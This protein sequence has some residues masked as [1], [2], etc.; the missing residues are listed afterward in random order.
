MFEIAIESPKKLATVVGQRLPAKSRLITDTWKDHRADRNSSREEDC[1]IGMSQKC[2][3]AQACDI[4]SEPETCDC[5]KTCPGIYQF[6]F[7]E[8]DSGIA[9]SQSETRHRIKIPVRLPD[10]IL[11]IPSNDLPMFLGFIILPP[12]IKRL[13]HLG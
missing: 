1:R 7:C 9:A 3:H 4:E 10:L 11:N 13:F 6:H 5:S 2:P 12:H 8:K